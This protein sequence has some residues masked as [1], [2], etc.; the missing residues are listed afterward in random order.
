MIHEKVLERLRELAAP[1]ANI[2]LLHQNPTARPKDPA[3]L[4]NG[5]LCLLDVVKRIY[6]QH[7]I[8]SF[9]LEG[10][11][12]GTAKHDLDIGEG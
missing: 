1:A 4:G 11:V 3:H 5:S 6:A 9:V 7:D 12:L 2:E 8:E 10:N